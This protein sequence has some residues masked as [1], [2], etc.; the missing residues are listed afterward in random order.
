MPDLRYRAREADVENC[1]TASGEVYM[2]MGHEGPRTLPKCRMRGTKFV[3]NRVSMITAALL[4]IVPLKC[5]VDSTKVPA[6]GFA[7]ST[8]DV[9]T[10]V[11]GRTDVDVVAFED[12]D[13]A[14]PLGD[15]IALISL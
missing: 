7:F 2:R 15:S 8:T 5:P 6:V 3:R 9:A 12:E 4:V 1:D 14:F 13:F 11:V 10:E